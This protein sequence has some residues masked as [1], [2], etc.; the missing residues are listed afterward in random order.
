MNVVLYAISVLH[1]IVNSVITLDVVP[2]GT[3]EELI[4]VWSPTINV[5]MVCHVHPYNDILSC[6]ESIFLAMPSWYGEHD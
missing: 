5:R 6:D 4:M 3:A 2:M 1:W